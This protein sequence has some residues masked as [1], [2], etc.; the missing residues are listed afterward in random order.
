MNPEQQRNWKQQTLDLV[1]QALAESRELS[2]YLVYKGA[3][4]LALRLG[5]MHRASYDLDANLLEV[6]SRDFPTRQDQ[7]ARLETLIRQAITNFVETQSLVRFAL[8]NVKVVHRPRDVHPLGWNA[9]DVSI[10]LHDH[11]QEGTRGLPT[12]TFDIAAPES[13]GAT[14]IAP[15][16]VGEMEVFAYT[17]ERLAG[18][19]LRAFLSS[20]P[21]YRTKVAKPGEAVRVKDI[22]DVGKILLVHPIEHLDFWATAGHEFRLACASRFID[23]AGI[24]TFEEAFEVTQATYEADPTIPKDLSFAEAWNGIRNIIALWGRSDLV[25]FQYPL[26]EE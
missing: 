7:V 5:T 21:S 20:L 2:K 22:Y 12:I 23:C 15:L 13:L 16:K 18:E 17:L 9:F 26:P 6:F 10:R 25:D 4:I 3:R 8:E 1:F 24:G 11:A 19:K 14:A